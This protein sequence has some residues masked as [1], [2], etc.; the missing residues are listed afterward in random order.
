M[1]APPAERCPASEVFRNPHE[2]HLWR[3]GD[4]LC[5]VWRPA[6][7]ADPPPPGALRCDG[8]V[9]E[10]ARGPFAG[11]SWGDAWREEEEKERGTE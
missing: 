3:W 11:Q 4:E 1:T 9:P 7:D 2:P 8:Q 10:P 5:Y 6:D